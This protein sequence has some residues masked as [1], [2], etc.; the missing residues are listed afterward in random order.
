MAGG[1][2]I[3]G[4]FGIGGGVGNR[5]GGGGGVNVTEVNYGQET[6][7]VSGGLQSWHLAASVATAA[8]VGLVLL[9]WTLPR[10]GR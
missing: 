4:N 9:R 2:D 1:L 3:M 6:A 5:R 8:T 7:P 10:R